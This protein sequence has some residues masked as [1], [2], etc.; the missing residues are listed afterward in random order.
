LRVR[1][2]KVRQT[3]ERNAS[4]ERYAT[5]SPEALSKIRTTS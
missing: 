4:T 3:R 5:S 2:A 1:R